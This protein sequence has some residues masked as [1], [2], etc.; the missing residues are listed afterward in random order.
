MLGGG[1]YILNFH[2]IVRGCSHTKATEHGSSI[3]TEDTTA[4][5]IDLGYMLQLDDSSTATKNAP[6]TSGAGLK[7][8]VHT[9]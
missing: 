3:S 2:D 7:G 4:L 5:N 8:T 1:D 9:V 6:V